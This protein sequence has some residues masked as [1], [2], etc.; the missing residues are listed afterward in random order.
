MRDI[1]D[2]LVGLEIRSA[3]LAREAQAQ[4][5]VYN[6]ARN[7]LDAA[8]ARAETL[9][10]QAAT[11]GR[12]AEASALRAGQL[13]A[14][15]ARTGGGDVSLALLMS[16]DADDLLAT[17]GTMGRLTEQSTLIYRQAIADRNAAASLTDQARVAETQRQEL[18]DEAEDAAAAAETAASAAR[19]E[20]AQQYAAA[21]QLYDQL[22]SLK[23]TTAQ[24]ERQYIAGLAAPGAVTQPVPGAPPPAGPGPAPNPPAPAPAAPPAPAPAPPPA[25]SAAQGA[26]DFAWAQVGDRYVYGG[27]GPDGWDCSGLTKAAYA[28]VGVYIGVHGASS[29]YN[30]LANQGRLVS[31]GSLIPGDLV[32]YSSGGSTSGAKYH[33]AI[34]IGGGLMIEAPY[35]PLN[36]QVAPLRYRDLV[37]YAARP[38]G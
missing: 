33:T 20:L 24:V 38:T 10:A 12:Q 30:Y 2:L 23:G 3:D 6:A 4:A 14:S 13:I 11:A 21:E 22:A 9:D 1:Q 37:P 8:T 34:Y 5:E 31:V 16:P 28:A 29:Q 7:E 26:I 17:L 15:V 35:E 25:T 27:S 19:Q 32:F 36:V 18:S